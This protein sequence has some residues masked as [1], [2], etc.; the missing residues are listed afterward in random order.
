M[1]K[2]IITRKEA[3]TFL[4]ISLPTL[5]KRTDEGRYK[6]VKQGRNLMY[7][8]EDLKEAESE[9]TAASDSLPVPTMDDLV[10]GSYGNEL[11]KLQEKQRGFMVLLNNE[12]PAD[13]LK[14]H[15]TAKRKKD[16][17]EVPTM[18]LPIERVEYLLSR[19]FTKWWVEILFPPQL[20]GNSVSVTV[21]L[22]VLNPITL[23]NEFQDGTGGAPVQTNAGATATDAA[24][25]KSN[26]FAEQCRF[27]NSCSNRSYS[28]R[29]AT[30]I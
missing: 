13:W 2:G 24:Q 30:Q 4:G 8:T 25:V 26:G 11:T 18:Y 17:L 22:W 21:R 20:L 14:Q 27:N 29:Y 12:P 16:G 28:Y 9:G 19:I 7:F 6:T 23:E 5:K 10:K 15:P 1:E 3:A